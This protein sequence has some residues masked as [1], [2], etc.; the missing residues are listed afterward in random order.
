MFCDPY[1]ASPIA[2][3][4][5][6]FFQSPHARPAHHAGGD[7]LLALAA[8]EHH[9][10]WLR[11]C[12][13]SQWVVVGSRSVPGRSTS[14]LARLISAVSCP[15]YDV[16]ADEISAGGLHINGLAAPLI[17][18][19]TAQIEIACLL[20]RA[21][22]ILADL[23]FPERRGPR[24][25]PAGSAPPRYFPGPPSNQQA[26]LPSVTFSRPGAS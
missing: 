12:R 4:T 11:Q 21:I 25:R 16:S 6:T 5:R 8:G 10:R 14:L 20:L 9:H 22:D 18:R 26:L 2:C 23:Q 3:S 19:C 17:W 13:A 1:R 7:V 15:Q 24:P